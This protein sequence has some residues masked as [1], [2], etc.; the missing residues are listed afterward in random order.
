[1]AHQIQMAEATNGWR[2][3]LPAAFSSL[4]WLQWGAIRSHW[5]MSEK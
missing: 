2:I 4:P 1:M 3:D 5:R